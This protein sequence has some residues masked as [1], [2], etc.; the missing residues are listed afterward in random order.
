MFLYPSKLCVF[1][2]FRNFFKIS[3]M[4]LFDDYWMFFYVQ[5]PPESLYFDSSM[6]GIDLR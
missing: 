1:L 2:K 4:L 6:P 3:I 5:T